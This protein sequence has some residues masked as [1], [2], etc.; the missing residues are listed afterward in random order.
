M[1]SPLKRFVGG[2][3]IGF[4]L[5]TPIILSRGE[6]FGSRLSEKVIVLPLLSFDAF[7]AACLVL[8]GFTCAWVG[9]IGTRQSQP[10][11][12]SLSTIETL[13]RRRQHRRKQCSSPRPRLDLFGQSH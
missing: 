13:R 5:S 11:F 7:A 12:S 3:L 1:I 10:S 2:L 4:F 9:I 6:L 8:L